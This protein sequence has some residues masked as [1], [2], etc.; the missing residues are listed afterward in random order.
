MRSLKEWVDY[1]QTI[2]SSE[3]E[4][5]LDRVAVLFNRLFPSGVSFKVISVAGTNGKGSCVA[6]LSSILNAQEYAVAEYTSPHLVYFNER[7][8]INN[9]YVPDK[10]IVEAFQ[11]I[12]DNRAEITLTFFE[13]ATLVA[14]YLFE[15]AK[16]DVAI[17]E[18]G[19]GGRLDAVNI[20]DA[21]VAVISNI[22][23]D[24]M[25][26]LGNTL[27]EIGR[28][29]V[30]I[31]RPGKPCVIGM[32][33][34]PKSIV[35]YCEQHNIPL[36][37]ADKE[38]SF[39]VDDVRQTWVWYGQNSKIDDLQTPLNKMPYQINNAA[40]V[41][42]AID[43]LQDILPVEIDACKTGIANAE[44]LGRCQLLN[45]NP[46]VLLDVAHNVDSVRNLAEFIRSRKAQ[47]RVIAVCAMLRDK[48]ISDCYQLLSGVV[49]EWFLASL[50]VSRGITS[51]MLKQEI[52]GAIENSTILKPMKCFD[53]VRE[54][55][56]AAKKDLNFNDCLL[57]FG[58]FHTV[59]DI[60]EH[61]KLLV[62]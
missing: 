44:I 55:Y 13:F 43:C 61:E 33:S 59:G 22:A 52:T 35:S 24:H 1:T 30:G 60:I 16:V 20:L 45:S 4:L 56:S 40:V 9:H 51:E 27:E 34:P 58:S 31:A 8:K 3:M 28:E 37:C 47:G 38:F 23:F 49:D 14:I 41:L 25:A 6:M 46:D 15:K 12:E 50:H 62:M 48:Q 53:S 18:V 17:M 21:D 42:Q 11:C 7:F 36:Y 54:A 19:L 2:H 10:E 26:W 57:V 29:K 5:Q 39:A 32:A